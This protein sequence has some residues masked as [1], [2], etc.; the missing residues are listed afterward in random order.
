[1]SS[2]NFAN[3]RIGSNSTA[4][5]V[6][7]NSGNSSVTIYD[8][9]ISGPGFST[10]GIF[11]G[12]ILAAG[13][14]AIVT[15]IFAPAATGSVTGSVTITSDAANSPATISLSGSGVQV[16]SHSVT[17][18]WTASLAPAIAYQI[19]RAATSGGPYNLLNSAPVASTY[20]LD[21]SIEPGQTYYYVV[22][23]VD[24]GGTESTYSD[25]VSGVIPTP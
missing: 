9:A 18:S 3:V 10:S 22:T 13:Q 21:L 4:E 1:M 25:E 20:F 6:L 11:T 5:V 8:V 2:V 24:S 19:Y 17:L 16:D 15:A 12:Q 7:T 14:T 23:A